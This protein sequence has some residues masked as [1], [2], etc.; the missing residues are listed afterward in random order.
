VHDLIDFNLNLFNNH[1]EY[2]E[3]R[4]GGILQD[5]AVLNFRVWRQ[6]VQEMCRLAE[7]W[8]K[9]EQRLADVVSAHGLP[10]C[11]CS[12]REIVDVRHI[13]LG[14]TY[15]DLDQLAII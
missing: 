3:G 10:L 9:A 1:D 2:F 15:I 11:P 14:R 6:R 4:D 5:P 12:S 8:Q 7:N 13:D